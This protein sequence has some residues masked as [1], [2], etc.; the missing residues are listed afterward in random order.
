MKLLVLGLILIGI[1][2]VQIYQIKKN[3]EGFNKSIDRMLKDG[4]KKWNS[5][6]GF[7]YSMQAK[8]RNDW[9]QERDAYWKDREK[10]ETTEVNT[11]QVNPQTTEWLKF[12]NDNELTNKNVS[13]NPEM[14]RL[15]NS[16]MNCRKI[17]SC[18]DLQDGGNC[19]YC[20]LDEEFRHGNDEGPFAH[21]CKPKYWTKD[22]ETCKKMKAQKECSEAK[23]CGDLTGDKAAKCG[24][25]PTTG[26][27]VPMEKIGDSYHAVYDEDICPSFD[28]LL[29]ADKCAEFATQNPCITPYHATGPHSTE[30]L[31]RLW[32]NSKC[33]TNKPYGKSYP[34]LRKLPEYVGKS[35]NIIGSMMS[36][37]FE[38]TKSNDLSVAKN[39]SIHCY[40]NFNNI[41]VCDEKYY[42]D[43][44][45]HP[46]CLMKKFT[47]AGCTVDGAE[48]SKI[49]NNVKAHVK[50]MNSF[51]KENEKY[52][53]D[54]VIYKG[55]GSD[56]ATIDS[57]VSD[58]QRIYS[59][60]ASA[61]NQETRTETSNICFG[62]EAPAPPEVKPGDTVTLGPLPVSEG[63]LQFEGIVTGRK[64][65]KFKVMWTKTLRDG[66][67]RKREDMS[68]DEQAKFLGWDGV[69][70]TINVEIDD[71]FLPGRLF[72]K[73]SCST[74][75]SAC[76]QTCYSKRITV[77]NKFPRPKDCVLS[78]WSDFSMCSKQCD[79][80][81]GPGIRY[82]TRK[83]LYPA[84]F[85]GKPC[86]SLR[87]E[88]TCGTEQCLN[89]NFVKR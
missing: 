8:E 80:G 67:E 40:G 23:D 1:V 60:S 73:S 72:V 33:T 53:S 52:T 14:G 25:C 58:I 68:I 84:K 37:T 44:L 6:E 5:R 22:K 81:S 63:I 86:G 71:Y 41:N 42:N 54:G 57:Y 15:E 9:K 83:V 30:C 26:K 27:I 46:E 59:L 45:P 12:N 43:G 74:N 61:L 85:R 78:D 88:E 31:K 66:V 76:D 50:K 77:L 36:D 3:K 70:P 65:G 29:P 18:D 32:S 51:K 87:Y 55:P 56:V 47:E 62:K 39:N 64:F 20:A 2:L 17:E 4:E 82:K 75:K 49:S 79:D 16:I 7:S 11:I 10:R 21:V 28:G 34:E 48:Y 35:Y 38:K 24:F 69:K 19:G 89:Q 13:V